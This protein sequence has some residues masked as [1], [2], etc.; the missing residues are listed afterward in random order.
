MKSWTAGERSFGWRGEIAVPSH[1]RFAAGVCVLAAALLMMCGAGGAVAVA[2]PGS[3]GSAAHGDGGSNASGQGSTTASSPVGTATDTRRKTIQ[4]VTSTLSSGRQPGQQTSTGSQGPKKE[5]GG[6]VTKGGNKDSG[7]VAVPNLVAAVPNVVAPVQN[8]VVAVP[9][10]V[11]PVPDVVAPVPDVVALVSDLVAPVPNLGA[12]VPDVIAAI[13]DML[14][15]APG[16]VVPL[17]QLPSDLASSFGVSG[18]APVVDGR[19]GAGRSAAADAS[20]ASQLLLPLPVAGIPGVP[21]VGT[22]A[23]AAAL[24]AIAK[25]SVGGASSLPGMEPPAPND[26]AI[27]MGVRSF[28]RHAIKLL[29]A[30]SLWA[31]AAVALPGVG[32][33]LMLTLAGVRVGYRQAKAGFAVR[34]AGIARFARPGT[35]GV[36]RSGSLVVVRPRALRVVRPGALSAGGLL[37]K[38][39]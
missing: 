37:D 35:L 29:P 11:A 26:G 23:G 15:S 28:I 30:A 24:G 32:G 22:A 18:A 12:P 7:L 14:T 19:G 31:L 39:A 25:T 21:M 1:L 9:S 20:V 38:V 2:D 27:P 36:V 17:T 6:T 4:G 13:Q 8:V 33:L 3:R 10:V 5:P 34:T 16:A